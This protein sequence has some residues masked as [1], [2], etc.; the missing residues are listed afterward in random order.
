[1]LIGLCEDE[2]PI[3]FGSTRLKVKVTRII[4]AIKIFSAHYLENLLL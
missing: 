4:L 3:D 1:M 2:N